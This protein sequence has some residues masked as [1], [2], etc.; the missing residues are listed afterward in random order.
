MAE[1]F[2]KL[3]IWQEANNLALEVYRVTKKFPSDERFSLI[4][5]VRRSGASVSANI[6]E[7]CG[8]YSVKDR[9]NLLIIARGSIYETRSFLSLSLG[10]TYINEDEFEIMDN[11][12]ELLLRRLNS[13]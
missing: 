6:A 8:R 12:Y 7:S 13:F 11:R 1:S 5:Q 3:E 4:D 9:V 10:L 2:R